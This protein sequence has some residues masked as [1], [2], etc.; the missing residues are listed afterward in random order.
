MT[1]RG[2]VSKLPKLEHHTGVSEYSS[3]RGLFP[4][5]SVA[6]GIGGHINRSG[7]RSDE[8]LLP[9]VVRDLE[10]FRTPSAS[11]ILGGGMSAKTRREQGHAVNL[12]DQIFDL[13]RS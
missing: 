1:Q 12:A 10:M 3:S 7:A 9:G 2:T 4:T 5:P 11:D 13:I 6:D 8:M